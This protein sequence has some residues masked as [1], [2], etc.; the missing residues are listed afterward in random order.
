MVR[1][2]SLERP[3]VVP[4]GAVVPYCGANAAAPPISRSPASQPRS[5]SPPD[6]YAPLK[7]RGA[8]TML[9]T[10]RTT[11]P[12]VTTPA[13]ANGK[14]WRRTICRKIAHGT[15]TL[16]IAHPTV[17]ATASGAPPVCRIGETRKT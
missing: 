14:P 4:S 7:A 2:R 9:V 8:Y 17:V 12:R 10:D 13:G 5:S 15:A 16:A 3:R 6:A 1:A 11:R